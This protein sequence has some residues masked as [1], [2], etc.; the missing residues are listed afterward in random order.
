[1]GFPCMT[2]TTMYTLSFFIDNKT[3]YFVQATAIIF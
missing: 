1:M 2:G 3:A